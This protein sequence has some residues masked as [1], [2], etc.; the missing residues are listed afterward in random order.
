MSRVGS[1]R[2]VA[3]RNRLNSGRRR[4][5]HRQ[6]G[7][8]VYPEGDD[9]RPPNDRLINASGRSSVRS[10]LTVIIHLRKSS[11]VEARWPDL[12]AALQPLSGIRSVRLESDD[13]LITVCYD[14]RAA[15]MAEIVRA[16]EDADAPVVAVAQRHPRRL[17]QR[18][19]ATPSLLVKRGSRRVVR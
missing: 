5:D 7:G 1:L 6:F 15:T 12:H 10:L 11:L 8:M 17:R 14:R 16:L 13:S 19:R 18:R 2:S 3:H 4:L 9:A